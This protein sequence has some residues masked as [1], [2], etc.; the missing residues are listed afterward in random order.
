MLHTCT[1]II[2]NKFSY[3]LLLSSINQRHGPR[4]HAQAL[5]HRPEF[6]SR[7]GFDVDLALIDCQRP[8]NVLAHGGDVG[9]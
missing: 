8:G 6:F 7:F 2:F 4:L 9:G 3:F 5:P 1:A